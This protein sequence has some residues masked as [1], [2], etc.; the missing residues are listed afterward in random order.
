MSVYLDANATEILRVEA[1]GAALEAMNLEGNPSSVHRSGRLARRALEEARAT[2][3]E[4][5]G[6]EASQVV[7]TSGGTEANAL[8]CHAFGSGRRLLIGATEHDAVRRMA[9]GARV[10]PVAQDG[11]L[12]LSALERALDGGSPAFVC[13]MAANNETGV[14][15]PID[16][17]KSLCARHG[18]VLHVDAVQL[19]G[20]LGPS[21]IGLVLQGAMSVA[22]SGHKAGGLKGAGALIL[23]DTS[24]VPPLVPGGGQEQGRRGGT[25]ALPAIVSMAAAFKSAIAQDWSTIEALR[26]KIDQAAL[27]SGARITG[28]RIKARLPNT[29]ALILPDVSALTQ[30]MML[31]LA[32]F[33]VSAGAACSSGKVSRSHV[34]EAMGLGEAASHAI[35]VSLPWNIREKQVDDFLKAY[36]TMAARLTR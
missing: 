24:P 35:R 17:V 23:A 21:A 14:L 6:V 3:A 26:D 1:R 36:R 33:S 19:A 31:D 16:K 34:L 11:T 32:G 28:D 15:H 29:T 18:A 5:W 22:I 27:S 9:P 4:I 7:F 2:L 8:A 20:R 12:S 25:P 13:V 10:I 30:L